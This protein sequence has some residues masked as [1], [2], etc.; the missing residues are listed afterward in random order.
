MFIDVS[1]DVGESNKDLVQIFFDWKKRGQ[2]MRDDK[3]K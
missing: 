2:W 1:S 3:F